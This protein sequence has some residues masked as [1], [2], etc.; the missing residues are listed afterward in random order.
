MLLEYQD[1]II[2][3]W[4]TCTIFHFSKIIMSPLGCLILVQSWVMET[5]ASKIV[6]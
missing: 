1:Y 2:A 6:H 5:K 3:Q 4:V